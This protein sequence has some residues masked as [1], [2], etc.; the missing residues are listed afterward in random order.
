MKLVISAWS[1][2]RLSCSQPASGT[3]LVIHRSQP[4]PACSRHHQAF[5]AAQLS[6][7]LASLATL[8]AALHASSLARPGLTLKGEKQAR[9]DTA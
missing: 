2:L 1:V 6:A 4:L 9:P 3:H 5:S 7:C 8:L